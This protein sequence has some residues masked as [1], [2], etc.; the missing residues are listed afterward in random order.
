MGC[1]LA[2]DLPGQKARIRLMLAIAAARTS[3]E[4]AAYFA[5]L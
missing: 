2:G 3:E 1:L 5:D 4:L